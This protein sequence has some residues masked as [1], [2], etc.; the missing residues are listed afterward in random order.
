M[1]PSFACV[2]SLMRPLGFGGIM[3]ISLCVKKSRES[4][5]RRLSFLPRIGVSIDF[6][7]KKYAYKQAPLLE[8]VVNLFDR[9]FS[10]KNLMEVAKDQLGEIEL[11]PSD[12]GP[13]GASS[14]KSKSR[15]RKKPKVL[16]VR[17]KAEPD[18]L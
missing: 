6:A 11:T 5:I 15:I 18:V 7:G 3:A 16:T 4:K 13:E 12:G 9:G 17:A 10:M 14:Q 8:A 1:T 2:I